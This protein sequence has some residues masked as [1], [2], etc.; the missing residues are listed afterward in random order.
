MPEVFKSPQKRFFKD[1]I[2]PVFHFDPV[3]FATLLLFV[4]FIFVIDSLLTQFSLWDSVI[5][6]HLGDLTL[7]LIVINCLLFKACLAVANCVVP[8]FI[9][10]CVSAGNEIKEKEKRDSCKKQVKKYVYCK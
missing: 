3:F 2:R 10:R 1:L 9:T 7:L 6:L 4:V 5:W 8:L